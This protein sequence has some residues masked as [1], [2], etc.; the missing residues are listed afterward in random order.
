MDAH[1]ILHRCRKHAER[2]VLAQVGF[3][4]E[5]KLRKIG[6]VFEVAGVGAGGIKGFAVVRHVFVCVLQAPAQPVELQLAQLIDAGFFHVLQLVHRSHAFS[7][8]A[9][10]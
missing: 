6:E 8:A 9:D 3:G 10:R 1:D 4:G 7:P 5:R 2:V